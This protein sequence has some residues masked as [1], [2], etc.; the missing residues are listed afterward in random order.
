MLG[1][2]ECPLRPPPKKFS[3]RKVLLE[4]FRK[5]INFYLHLLEPGHTADVGLCKIFPFEIV[6]QHLTFIFHCFRSY[7]Q[8]WQVSVDFYWHGKK[9]HNSFAS[10][11]KWTFVANQSFFNFV[12]FLTASWRGGTGGRDGS[13]I[14]WGRQLLRRSA[15][16]LFDH[17]FSKNCMKMKS[18]QWGGGGSYSYWRE[19]N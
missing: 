13:R 3:T 15:N 14:S 10:F 19:A 18:R 5:N 7:H 11:R 6:F 16:L 9:L 17:F 1:L 8:G 4:L 12:G 2:G